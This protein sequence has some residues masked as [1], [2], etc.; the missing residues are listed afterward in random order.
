MSK[1]PKEKAPAWDPGRGFVKRCR[2]Q[3]SCWSFEAR[4]LAAVE[5]LLT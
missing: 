3:S 5:P 4:L 2:L 1:Q